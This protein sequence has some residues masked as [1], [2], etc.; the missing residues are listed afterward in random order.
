MSPTL[1]EW[2]KGIEAHNKR[3]GP[4]NLEMVCRWITQCALV[5]KGA[6]RSNVYPRRGSSVQLF[7]EIKIEHSKLNGDGAGGSRYVHAQDA[8]VSV[9]YGQS[10]I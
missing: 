3:E 5:L 6:C 7:K 8:M 2:N 10:G 4:I 9:L 1:P